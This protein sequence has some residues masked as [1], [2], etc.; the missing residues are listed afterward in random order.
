M[1]VTL[2][3]RRVTFTPGVGVPPGV[4]VVS[5]FEE[6]M[7]K[8]GMVLLEGLSG[9]EVEEFEVLPLLELEL[10]EEEAP[11]LGVELEGVRVVAMGGDVKV[12][13]DD[14]AGRVLSKTDVGSRIAACDVTDLKCGVPFGPT[15]PL[16][17]PLTCTLALLPAVGTFVVVALRTKPGEPCGVG[18]FRT[19]TELSE[20]RC[21]EETVLIG[22]GCRAEP[23]R[24][25]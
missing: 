3:E 23:W 18:L 22:P 24:W 6:F 20:A 25:L 15:F 21:G 13:V 4:K 8:E 17:L 5:L 11:G 7:K 16:P 2:A 14:D 9:E 1:G 12:G 19:F 10:R